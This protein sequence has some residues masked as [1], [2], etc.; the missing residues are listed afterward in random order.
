[1]KG[2]QIDFCTPKD[3]SFQ[4][5][6]FVPAISDLLKETDSFSNATEAHRIC[7]AAELLKVVDAASRAGASERSRGVY[8]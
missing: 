7:I 6:S 8:S 3:I 5:R 4:W 2:N 1:M